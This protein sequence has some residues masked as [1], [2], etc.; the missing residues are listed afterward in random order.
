[1]IKITVKEGK[2]GRWRWQAVLGGKH[3]CMSGVRGYKTSREAQNAAVKAFSEDVEIRI[4][5]GPLY[6]GPRG[7]EPREDPEGMEGEEDEK[8][9]T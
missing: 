7:F 1:M 6:A 4:L 3:V 9:V 8:D 5:L 2:H